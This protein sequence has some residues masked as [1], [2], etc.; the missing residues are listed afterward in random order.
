MLLVRYGHELMLLSLRFEDVEA[1]SHEASVGSQL[2]TAVNGALS[3]CPLDK[4]MCIYHLV[5]LFSCLPWL[6]K[7]VLSET[8]LKQE[9]RLQQ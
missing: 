9:R 5:G 1:K 7:M 4:N 8:G 6:S 3:S 2:D